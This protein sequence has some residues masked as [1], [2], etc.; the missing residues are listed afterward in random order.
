MRIALAS[1][2]YGAVFRGIENFIYGIHKDFLGHGIKLSIICGANTSLNE[3][4]EVPKERGAEIVSFSLIK[5]T[6]QKRDFFRY[7]SL[8]I[9]DVSFSFSSFPYLLRSNFDVLLLFGWASSYFGTIIQKFRDTKIVYH[10][11]GSP[12]PAVIFQYLPLKHVDKVIAVSKYIQKRIK[13]VVGLDSTVIY[14]G[15][16]TSLFSPTVDGCNIRFRYNIPEDTSVILF[17][18]SLTQKKGVHTLFHAFSGIRSVRKDVK[19]ILVGAGPEYE[20]LRRLSVKLN[21]QNDIILTGAVKR[22]DLPYFYASSDMVIIPSEF[23][24]PISLV[25]AE[26]LSSGKPVIASKVGGMPELVKDYETGL[27][28]K[29]GSQRQLE[30][31]INTLLSDHSLAK[32]LSDNARKLAVSILDWSKIAQ[33]YVKVFDQ[34]AG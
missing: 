4:I 13:E 20:N 31:R 2:G 10:M 29:A 26:A 17:V 21:V 23:Q 30:T 5:R 8:W 24:E 32:R 28:F 6:M 22:S 19:L 25:L 16:D 11:G 7:V 14:N 9:E 12:H 3:Y 15:V 33:Q 1:P 18:G 27:L 34:I